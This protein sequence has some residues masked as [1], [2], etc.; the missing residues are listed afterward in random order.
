MCDVHATLRGAC[1]SAID[2][3][4]R[5]HGAGR[6]ALLT[7]CA[8]WR[9]YMQS[10]PSQVDCARRTERHTEA[11]LIAPVTG[12]DSNTQGGSSH[13]RARRYEDA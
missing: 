10:G 3:R 11:A 9:V 8:H 2:H 4:E 5:E 13:H 12:N 6:D 1:G 7:P